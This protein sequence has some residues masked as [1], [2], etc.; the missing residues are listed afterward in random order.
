V[1]ILRFDNDGLA[2]HL[3]VTGRTRSR[4]RDKKPRRIIISTNNHDGTFTDGEGERAVSTRKI[5]D[6]GKAFASADYDHDGLKIFVRDVLREEFCYHNKPGGT[7]LL[8]DV[9]EQNAC[10]R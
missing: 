10:E 1:A 4:W 5:T 2:G 3:V 8:P 6:G 9:R 7:E